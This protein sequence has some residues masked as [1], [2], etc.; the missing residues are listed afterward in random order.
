MPMPAGKFR[1]RVRIEKNTPVQQTS[2][3]GAG[4]MVDNWAVLQNANAVPAMI[5]PLRGREFLA[6][7][8]VQSEVSSKVIIRYRSDID[9]KV[10]LVQGTKIYSPIAWMVDAKYGSE[11]LIAYVKEGVNEG[12]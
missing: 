3:P 10:R 7:Q 12:G 9:N 2:G 11:F 8:A 6:A 5:E 4:S 1:F